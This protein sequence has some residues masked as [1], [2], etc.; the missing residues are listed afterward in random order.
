MGWARGKGSGWGAALAI[1]EKVKL[2]CRVR[3]E[4]SAPKDNLNSVRITHASSLSALIHGLS[5][6]GIVHSGTNA[7]CDRT[8]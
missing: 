8:R 6:L 7:V 1:V 2:D 4:E 3:V 5:R